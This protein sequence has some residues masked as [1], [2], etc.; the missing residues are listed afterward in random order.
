MDELRVA[1]ER[2]LVA[3]GGAQVAERA[4]AYAQAVREEHACERC[5][6]AAARTL[7]RTAKRRPVPADL[8]EETRSVMGTSI[9]AQHVPERAALEPGDPEGWWRLQAPSIVRAA[10][11]ELGPAEVELVCRELQR[12]ASLGLVRADEAE[13]RA[14]L[15]WEDE[16][17]PTTERRWWMRFLGMVRGNHDGTEDGIGTVA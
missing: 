11:P 12:Q 9:H 13:V 17:G 10:W 2:M 15:G 14:N 5:A 8:L 7:T 4:G 16:W 1:L 3:F 6:A